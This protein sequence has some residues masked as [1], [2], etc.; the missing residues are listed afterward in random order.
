VR[1]EARETYKCVLDNCDEEDSSLA[2]LASVA[3]QSKDCMS[4]ILEGARIVY[5]R[6]QLP[7]RH[8]S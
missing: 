3:S 1:K 5:S 7:L 6:N 2:C 8:L 4:M